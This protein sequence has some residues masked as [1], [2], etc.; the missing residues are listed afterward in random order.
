MPAL[1]YGPRA[2]T[3]GCGPEAS[4]ARKID[5]ARRVPS[6]IATISSDF[7]IPGCTDAGA[8]AGAF[9]S[10]FFGSSFALGSSEKATPERRTKRIN[11]P[12]RVRV[13]FTSLS[14]QRISRAARSRN[15]I[16]SW[17]FY[18]QRRRI[19]KWE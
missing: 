4:S 14:S 3:T 12:K 19:T 9:F 15:V 17:A 16:D 2:K 10:S 13:R 18:R 8:G 11:S 7:A 5:V 1:P 6:C